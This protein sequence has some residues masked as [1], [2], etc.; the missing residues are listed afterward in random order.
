MFIP[1]FQTQVEGIESRWGFTPSRSVKLWQ[2]ICCQLR[3]PKLSDMY[4]LYT[5]TFVVGTKRWWFLYTIWI[6]LW[7]GKPLF[8]HFHRE[9]HGNKPPIDRLFS[10]VAHQILLAN[11]PT[12]SF[13]A[14]TLSNTPSTLT[15]LPGRSRV[16]NIDQHQSTWF[17]T[18]SSHDITINIIMRWLTNWSTNIVLPCHLMAIDLFTGKLTVYLLGKFLV[19][20]SDFPLNQSIDYGNQRPAL[21]R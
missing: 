11:S 16:F 19:S 17:T 7:Q 2:V 6:P 13:G 12:L 3:S 9:H 1:D 10:D 20:A 14:H 21:G 18:L 15:Q 8:I 4:N 5:P